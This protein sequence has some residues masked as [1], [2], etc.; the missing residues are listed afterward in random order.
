MDSAIRNIRV[1]LRLNA[2]YQQLSSITFIIYDSRL[3]NLLNDTTQLQ[4]YSK[5][6]KFA[7]NVGSKH[8]YQAHS[9]PESFYRFIVK[10]ELFIE[11][12]E[13]SQ[14]H[15]LLINTTLRK[16]DLKKLKHSFYTNIPFFLSFSPMYSGN[17]KTYSFVNNISIYEVLHKQRTIKKRNGLLCRYIQCCFTLSDDSQI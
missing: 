12:N 15:N 3:N 7:A 1:W 13:T 2:F 5:T 10:Y 17:H 4:N 8:N 11:N 6:T 9:L 16:V 14:L